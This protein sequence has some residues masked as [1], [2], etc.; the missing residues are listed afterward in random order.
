MG[1]RFFTGNVD[2]TDYNTGY[3]FCALPVSNRDG[4]A[5][6][7]ITEEFKCRDSEVI[8]AIK[9][10]PCPFSAELDIVME[11]TGKKRVEIVEAIKPVSVPERVPAGKGAPAAQGQE[12]KA[13]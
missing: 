9:N 3:V 8:K 7:Y 13:A 1:G 10:L 12:Q 11:S 6:G 5:F 4:T 2:G